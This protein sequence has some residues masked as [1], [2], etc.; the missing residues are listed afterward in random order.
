MNTNKY[1]EDLN[2]IIGADSS[3]DIYS[4]LDGYVMSLLVRMNSGSKEV[5]QMINGHAVAQYH[6]ATDMWVKEIIQKRV[7]LGMRIKN[8]VCFDDRDLEIEKS[9][10]DTLKESRLLN[11]E[12]SHSSLVAVFGDYVTILDLTEDISKSSAVIIK[13]KSVATAVELLFDAKWK[14]S[15]VF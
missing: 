8:L 12:E 14:D 15:K 7:E 4:G 11:V 9:N 3:W 6:Q 1:T 2:K 13:N 10:K 5:K